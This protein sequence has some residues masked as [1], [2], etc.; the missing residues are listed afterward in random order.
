MYYTLNREHTRMKQ[1]YDR[2][3]GSIIPENPGER[4]YLLF[5]REISET[6]TD[7]SG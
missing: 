3:E 5:G 7:I 1:F 2:E 4:E 6:A